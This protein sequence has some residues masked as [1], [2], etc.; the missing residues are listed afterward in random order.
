MEGRE[1]VA[2]GGVGLR[3]H[4]GG[5]GLRQQLPRRAS[6]D[7]EDKPVLFAS[8]RARRRRRARENDDCKE[9]RR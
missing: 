3:A 5:A 6:P 8:S 4:D 2:S 7:A 1:A 9:V